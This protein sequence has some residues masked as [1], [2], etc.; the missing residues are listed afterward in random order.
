MLRLLACWGLGLEIRNVS[1]C[2]VGI[3]V[4][5]QAMPAFR[6]LKFGLKS[7]NW[8][9]GLPGIQNEELTAKSI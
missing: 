4:E 3:P 6:S 2:F 7:T 9:P 5:I 1:A 8:S